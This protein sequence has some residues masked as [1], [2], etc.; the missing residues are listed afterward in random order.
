MSRTLR[1]ILLLLSVAG[2]VLLGSLREF[3]FVNINYQLKYL[4][5]E[6]AESYAHSFFDFL[7]NYSYAEIYYSKWWLM[8]IFTILFWVCSLLIVYF[9]KPERK[10]LKWMTLMYATLI[11]AAGIIFFFGW[12]FGQIDGG[13]AISRLVL[14]VAHSPLPV[15]IMAL[16][17]L[18][19]SQ[20]SPRLRSDYSVDEEHKP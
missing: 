10:W 7:N 1:I 18:F 11:V 6:Q 9:L 3:I 5:Y 20:S 16:A 4:Y 14:G 2:I 12:V 17:M 13:Y 8:A 15:M 19:L